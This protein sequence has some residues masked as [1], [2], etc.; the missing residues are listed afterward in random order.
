VIGMVI[1]AI[2][3]IFGGVFGVVTILVLTFYLLIESRALFEAGLRLVDPARRPQVREAASRIVEKVSAWLLGQLM[4]AGIIGATTALGLGL[5]GVPYF[6]VLA[7]LA[8]A[9]EFVP[10]VGP[11]LAAVPAL[12]LAA[13]V[14]WSL[15]LWTG[16]FYLVQQQVENH[17]LVPKL[18]SQQVGLLAAVVV[19]AILVG[20][21]AF[22]VSGAILAL[23]TAAIIQVLVQETVAEP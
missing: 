11:L 22:G 21:A 9:G 17:V 13:T 6:W 16:V 3:G 15:A 10:Y 5:L 7:I 23:P 1:G 20:G 2:G 14:S 12:V 4:L 8:A 19:I 18:M